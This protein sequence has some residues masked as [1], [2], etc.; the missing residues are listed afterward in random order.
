MWFIYH[1]SNLSDKLSTF[2]WLSFLFVCAGT[3]LFSTFYRVGIVSFKFN[4]CL[5]LFYYSSS[6]FNFLQA[7]IKTTHKQANTAN[8]IPIIIK[9]DK[10]YCSGVR[11]MFDG[12]VTGSFYFF[13]NIDL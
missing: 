3:K 6:S 11:I 2:A 7:K 1:S 4:F 13:S 5:S 10:S 8:V 9:I 12:G